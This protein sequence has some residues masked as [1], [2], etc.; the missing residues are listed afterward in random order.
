MVERFGSETM[1]RS[2]PSLPR[3]PRA[4]SDSPKRPPRPTPPGGWSLP[5]AYWQDEVAQARERVRVIRSTP[6]DAPSTG[7]ASALEELAVVLEQLSVAEEE[8]RAQ[9]DEL[10]RAQSVLDAERLRYRELFDHAP[11][12][13]IVTDRSGIIRAA[14]GAASS[15]L[16]CRADRLPGKPLAVFT[17]ALSRR[18]LRAALNTIVD[19]DDPVMFALTIASRDGRLHRTE[20][21]AAA[22]RDL[23]GALVEIRW[24]LVDR[25][26]QTRKEKRRRTRSRR[27]E[28]LVEERTMELRREQTLKDDLLATV[29]HEFRTALAAI[30]GYAELLDLG[31]HGELTVSQRG[32]VAHI[33]QAFHHLSRVVE[34]LL[35][36]ANVSA[37]RLSME[38]GDV[39]MFDVVRGLSDLV[40]PQ[41]AARDVTLRL[42]PIDPRLAARADAERLRQVLLNLLSNAVKF[43]RPHGTVQLAC[44]ADDHHVYIDI[45]DSGE[46]I[47][48]E[49]RETIFEP[50]IRLKTRSSSGTGLGLTISRS[51]ARAM[52]GDVTVAESTAAGSRFVVQL[53]RSTTFAQPHASA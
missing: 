13:Y 16:R 52:G 1:P 53:Q 50:F 15:L 10:E 48:A 29:S 49:S 7:S 40:A 5:L 14:N 17:R 23:H 37:G 46:G 21:N 25:T 35:S 9:N 42:E 8:L 39:L 45:V 34:D 30:G 28:A 51:L 44:R 47:P 36:Y 27:L 38:I 26:A 18:R 31:V 33:Q 43:T 3:N 20:I 11:V 22:V 6:G 24:L 41:A 4:M 12:P 19:A 32:D 2:L